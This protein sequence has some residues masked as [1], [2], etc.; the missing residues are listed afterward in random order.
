MAWSTDELLRRDDSAVRRP[1]TVA[2][3]DAGWSVAAVVCAGAVAT[4]WPVRDRSPL[5]LGRPA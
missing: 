3:L 4:W 2:G 5:V 1:D